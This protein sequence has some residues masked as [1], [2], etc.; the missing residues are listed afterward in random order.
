[1]KWKGRK[2]GKQEVMGRESYSLESLEE[3]YENLIEF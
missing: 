1:M 3:L 2:K